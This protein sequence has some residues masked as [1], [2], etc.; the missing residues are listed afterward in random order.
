M[1]NT[2]YST[3]YIVLPLFF[4]LLLFIGFLCVLLAIGERRARVMNGEGVSIIRAF[5]IG[6]GGPTDPSR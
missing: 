6:G 3:V 2:V 4:F 1:W 5:R